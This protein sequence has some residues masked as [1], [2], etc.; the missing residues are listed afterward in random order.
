MK[1]DKLDCRGCGYGFTEEFAESKINKQFP[2]P[3]CELPLQVVV[4]NSGYISIIKEYDNVKKYRKKLS[5]LEDCKYIKMKAEEYITIIKGECNP[6]LYDEFLVCGRVPWVM[7]VRKLLFQ[8]CD[9][10]GIHQTSI[11]FFFKINYG[12]IKFDIVKKYINS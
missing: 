4:K 10:M 6:K 2:C 11:M 9:M 1:G 7:K 3:K 8:D 5:K 12:F